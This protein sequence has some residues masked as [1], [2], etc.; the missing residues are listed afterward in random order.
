MKKPIHVWFLRLI[1]CTLAQ[2][3]LPEQLA[4][5]DAALKPRNDVVVTVTYQGRPLPDGRFKAILL[6]PVG[7]GEVRTA[8]AHPAEADDR[9][10]RRANYEWGG[11]GKNGQVRFDGFS[12]PERKDPGGALPPKHVR[13][14]IDLP[15]KGL[16][17][18]DVAETKP[19]LTLLKADLQPG[20][21][22]SLRATWESPSLQQW[23]SFTLRPRR[24]L[25]RSSL[26]THRTGTSHA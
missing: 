18:T 24:L 5:G 12:P 1:A 11:E 7:P 3:P 15:S 19:Y 9:K 10:W 6:E 26:Q 25:F 20:G 4:R 13:L 16:F 21:T 2:C 8:G 14:R 17:L 22:G 23:L